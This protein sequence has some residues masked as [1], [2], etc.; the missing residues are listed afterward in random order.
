MENR[1]CIDCKKDISQRT[2]M[3]KR[4]QDCSQKHQLGLMKKYR[5]T[6]KAEIKKYQQ[7]YYSRK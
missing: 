4:C 5:D 7:K 2:W 6:H 3:A 1:L